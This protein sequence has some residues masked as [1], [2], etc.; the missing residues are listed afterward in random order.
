[1]GVVWCGVPGQL[2]GVGRDSCGRPQAGGDT[3]NKREASRQAQVFPR[4]VRD[5]SDLSAVNLTAAAWR[6]NDEPVLTRGPAS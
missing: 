3:Q 5:G 1:M 6:L 2:T 4:R